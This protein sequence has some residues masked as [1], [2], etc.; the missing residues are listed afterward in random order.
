[1]YWSRAVCGKE[2]V[3][4]NGQKVFFDTDLWKQVCEI[5]PFRTIQ[6]GIGIPIPLEIVKKI[7]AGCVSQLFLETWQHSRD[8]PN[9]IVFDRNSRVVSS[10]SGEG[11]KGREAE[12]SFQSGFHQSVAVAFDE[13]L[14][15]ALT[16]I[17]F[18]V[19][20][21]LVC[22]VWAPARNKVECAS[23]WSCQTWW[24]CCTAKL[25]AAQTR[26]SCKRVRAGEL[27]SNG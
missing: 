13:T 19:F 25:P 3:I 4:K 14:E 23:D 22:G 26:W 20:S 15:S 17:S 24:L 9:K 7:S 6:C 11:G 16:E 18:L 12:S 10:L 21:C 2:L 5:D 8:W 1:M 27:G